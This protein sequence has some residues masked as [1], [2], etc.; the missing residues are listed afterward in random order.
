VLSSL[1]SKF[2][3]KLLVR[4]NLMLLQTRTLNAV[5]LA[6]PQVLPRCGLSVELAALL[7]GPHSAGIAWLQSNWLA[8]DW[9]ALL[10]TLKQACEAYC[11]SVLKRKP[12]GMISHQIKQFISR[13]DDQR[14]E[15]W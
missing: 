6:F 11:R 3:S 2:H 13:D 9:E 12:L 14:Y 8:D 15:R 7:E 5:I 10:Y 1:E 4:L